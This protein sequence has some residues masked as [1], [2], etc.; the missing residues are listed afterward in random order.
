[1]DARRQADR[2]FNEAE[3]TYGKVL[4]GE[5]KLPTDPAELEKELARLNGMVRARNLQYGIEAAVREAQELGIPESE[6]NGILDRHMTGL[7]TNPKGA[8]ADTLLYLQS[9]IR[10]KQG[11]HVVDIKESE[12]LNGML[13]RALLGTSTDADIKLLSQKISEANQQG[14]DFF[15]DLSRTG[16]N[17]AF[18]QKTLKNLYERDFELLTNKQGID[19][20][21]ELARQKNL[22]PGKGD[23]PDP[24]PLNRPDTA[25]YDLDEGLTNI[26]EQARQDLNNKPSDAQDRLDGLDRIE[27]RMSN[28]KAEERQMMSKAVQGMRNL[29]VSEFEA[30]DYASRN[31]RVLAAQN[32]NP[33]N[34]T[35]QLVAEGIMKHGSRRV[36][37]DAFDDVMGLISGGHSQKARDE[38][39]KRLGFAPLPSEIRPGWLYPPYH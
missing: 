17:N 29:G 35:A 12:A 1:M 16:T 20:L 30:L 9:S 5:R 2:L 25:E 21:R 23:S 15:D 7:D 3:E 8:R 33:A 37:M 27:R 19:K 38:G 24:G 39:A 6:I 32:D 26:R 36:S 11:Y 34:A 10:K 28:F 4:S 31:L 18:T 13:A 22:L 14:R